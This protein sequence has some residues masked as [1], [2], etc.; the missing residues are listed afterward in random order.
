MAKVYNLISTKILFYSL[1]LFVINYKTKVE[2][3]ISSIYHDTDH[4]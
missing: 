4:F 2:R 3:F 1:F